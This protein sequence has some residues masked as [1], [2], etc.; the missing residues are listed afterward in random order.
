MR[1]EWTV[2]F[3]HPTNINAIEYFN[4]NVIVHILFLQ[5]PKIY[6]RPATAT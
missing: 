1:I 6:Y 5:T 2:N 4:I 3:F